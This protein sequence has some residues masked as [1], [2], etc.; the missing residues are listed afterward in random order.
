MQRLGQKLCSVPN[1]WHDYTRIA[2]VQEHQSGT[3]L[4]TQ[5]TLATYAHLAISGLIK[6]TRIS[7]SGHELITGLCFPVRLLGAA[8]II[9]GKE[10]PVTA[11]ALT[12]CRLQS[13]PAPSFLKLLRTDTQFSWLVQN[14]Q[15]RDIYEQISQLAEIGCLSA[16][17]RLE[18][19]LGQF[20]LTSGT[21]SSTDETSFRLPLRLWEVAELIAVSPE[22]LSRILSAMQQEGILRRDK[23]SFTILDPKRLTSY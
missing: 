12:R 2:S 6:L 16:R 3:N 10:Y 18:R 14:Q 9:L 13:I 15:S 1:A 23:N 7:E 8:S 19:V 20:L 17:Q 22:H 21:N 5:G 11:V 4:Y